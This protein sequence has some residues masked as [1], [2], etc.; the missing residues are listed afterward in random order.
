MIIDWGF[1]G[2]SGLVTDDLFRNP[3]HESI[4][5]REISDH[6]RFSNQ[7]SIITDSD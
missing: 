3:I 6:Q 2:D 5:D 4:T 7:E 1:V